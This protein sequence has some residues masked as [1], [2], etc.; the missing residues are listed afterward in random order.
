M[1]KNYTPGQLAKRAR[2]KHLRDAYVPK[3]FDP[4]AKALMKSARIETAGDNKILRRRNREL[5]FE[6]IAL[7]ITAFKKMPKGKRRGV[8]R[9][10]QKFTAL[11]RRFITTRGSARRVLNYA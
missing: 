1:R 10:Q 6:E 5:K 7:E 11:L 9:A 3:P 2:R 4:D 8:L